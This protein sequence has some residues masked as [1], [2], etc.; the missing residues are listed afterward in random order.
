M[1]ITLRIWCSPLPT[2]K[3]IYSFHIF[4]SFCNVSAWVILFVLP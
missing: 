1:S 4:A 3:I 2:S